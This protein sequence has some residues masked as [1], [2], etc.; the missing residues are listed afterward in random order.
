MIFSASISSSV[1]SR[2]TSDGSSLSLSMRTTW[3]RSGSSSTTSRRRM[4]SPFM[5]EMPW[6][7]RPVSHHLANRPLSSTSWSHLCFVA[8][9]YRGLSVSTGMESTSSTP[10]ISANIAQRW[11]VGLGRENP[12]LKFRWSYGG[13]TRTKHIP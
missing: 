11:W 1:V 12:R 10:S 4:R 6:G 8:T 3:D 5:D 13:D 2:F 9:T 7:H